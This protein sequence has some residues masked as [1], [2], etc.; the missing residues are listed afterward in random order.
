MSHFKWKIFS[1]FVAFSEYPK[2]IVTIKLT[3]NDEI[4]LNLNLLL[5]K[6]K[7]FQLHKIGKI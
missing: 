6:S 4:L 1:N 7:Y 5:K 2:F 3:N